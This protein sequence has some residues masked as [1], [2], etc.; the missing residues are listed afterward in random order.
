M[1]EDDEV[2]EYFYNIISENKQEMYDNIAYDRTRYITVVM[3]NIM[4]NHNASAV[5]RTCD[6]F[7]IQDLHA[8]EKNQVYEVQRDI[9]RGADSWVDVH[10]HTKGELPSIE[11]LNNLKKKGYTLVSTSPHANMK[12]N[13][14]PLDNPIALVFGTEYKGISKEVETLSD[15]N[16]CV[17]MYG[18]TESFNIS[19]SVALALNIL[20]NRLENSELNWRLN[21]EEQVKLK[22]KWCSTIIRNGK[23]VEKEIRKRIFEKE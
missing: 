14:V 11:C 16:V 18:F 13:D 6:C 21:F 12:I 15:Y 3:E 2:L 1:T 9:A 7:G 8:I 20:R 23:N 4:K 17:P 19:V 22:I 5:L 10:S